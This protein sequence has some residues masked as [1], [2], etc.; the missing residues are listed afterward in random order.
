MLLLLIL[1][2]F[3]N[4]LLFFA[5]GGLTMA[6]PTSHYTFKFN[7]N[8]VTNLKL[9]FNDAVRTQTKVFSQQSWIHPWGYTIALHI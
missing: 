4:E 3:C 2:S 8:I 7:S 5:I 1:V 9:L 6:A